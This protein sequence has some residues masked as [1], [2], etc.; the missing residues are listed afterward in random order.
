MLQFEKRLFLE[1]RRYDFLPIKHKDNMFTVNV[2][3]DD[4]MIKGQTKNKCWIDAVNNTVNIFYLA[5]R[6]NKTS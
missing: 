6:E 1:R 3:K 5:I 2:F 4:K